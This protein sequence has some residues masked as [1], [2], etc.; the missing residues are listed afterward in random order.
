M[1][2]D[3]NYEANSVIARIK[4]F[5]GN[6]VSNIQIKQISEEPYNMFTLSLTLYGNKQVLAEY[7]RS[8][9][10]FYIFLDGKYIGLSK[11]TNKSIYRG[12]DSYSSESNIEHNFQA[13]DD[14][15]RSM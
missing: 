2:N 3:V 11:L 1:Y 4:R 10:G 13:L 6:N 8:T 9:L 12:F 14:V 7:E 5:W 15:L